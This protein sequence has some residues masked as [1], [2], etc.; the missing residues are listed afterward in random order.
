M[1]AFLLLGKL[2]YACGNYDEAL[3]NFKKADLVN[4]AEK[5]LPC[6]SI[7]I[8]AESYAIKGL[9]FF[10]L[11]PYIISTVLLFFFMIVIAFY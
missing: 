10:F 8:V 3:E 5:A 6:R 7:R 4:L 11:I 2:S 1:D 9:S